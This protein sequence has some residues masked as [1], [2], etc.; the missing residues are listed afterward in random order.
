MGLPPLR[1]FPLLAEPGL[2]I[3]NPR[4]HRVDLAVGALQSLLP[5]F[6]LQRELVYRGV[7]LLQPLPDGRQFLLL[8]IQPPLEF[9]HFPPQGRRQ[10]LPV[11]RLVLQSGQFLRLLPRI[12]LGI[13]QGPLRRR[14]L[15]PQAVARFVQ[16]AI[17]DLQ[18]RRTRGRLLLLEFRFLSGKAKLLVLLLGEQLGGGLGLLRGE[19]SGLRPPHRL[20]RHLPL[21]PFV[22]HI[23]FQFL[24]RLLLRS[25]GAPRLTQFC[26]QLH[27]ETHGVV[28]VVGGV[29]HQCFPEMGGEFVEALGDA[30]RDRR[31]RRTPASRRR[32]HPGGAPTAAATGGRYR[33]GDHG[34]LDG[35]DDRPRHEGLLRLRLLLLL[36][37][38]S[39]AVGHGRCPAEAVVKD[40]VPRGS[41]ALPELPHVG[42]RERPKH[43]L[44]G[45]WQLITPMHWRGLYLSLTGG[46]V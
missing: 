7:P 3:L 25:E 4:L 10:P 12:P 24:P 37:L 44:R 27:L 17:L 38:L 30:A 16:K 22:L 31:W 1:G 40:G 32:G 28:K 19:Q 42:G 46:V 2:Q 29:S 45:R 18:F 33:G 14:E 6:D 11:L 35:V 20:E 26:Q 9:V 21:P 15:R 41:A 23:F 5:L 39:D 8:G 43:L 13:L 34:L 36:L